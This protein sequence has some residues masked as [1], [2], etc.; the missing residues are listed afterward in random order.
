MKIEE[1][2]NKLLNRK[3][4]VYEIQTDGP[5]SKKQDVIDEIAKQEKK[6]KEQIVVIII[7]QAF[8]RTK[9]YATAYIYDSK[10]NVLKKQKHKKG[11]KPGEKREGGEN[12]S[13]GNEEKKEG[14]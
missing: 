13:E 3:E 5:T 8:G 2:D 14:N 4:L 6:D 1:K 11:P 7:K 10:D 12:A 9:C